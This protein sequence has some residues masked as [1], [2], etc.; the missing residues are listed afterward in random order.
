VGLWDSTEGISLAFADIEELLSKCR[1]SDCS[2][3][4]EPGCAVL[5]ALE[6]GSLPPEQW[7]LYQAQQREVNFAINHSAYLRQKQEFHKTIARNNK[8][9]RKGIR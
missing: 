9:M 1:F 8:A 5:A 7:K 3:R 4:T 2:H 6:D